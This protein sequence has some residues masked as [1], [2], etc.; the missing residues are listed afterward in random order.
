[1]QNIHE[2]RLKTFAQCHISNKNT[3][4]FN[5]RFAHLHMR[6]LFDKYS[7]LNAVNKISCSSGCDRTGAAEAR[8]PLGALNVDLPQIPNKIG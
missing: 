4:S 6:T 3:V 5:T 2:G 8:V 1:M 7:K